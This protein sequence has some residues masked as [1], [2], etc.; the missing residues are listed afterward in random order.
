MGPPSFS[1]PPPEP[2]ATAFEPNMSIGPADQWLC[3]V[4]AAA[5]TAAA[6]LLAAADLYDAGD[7]SGAIETARTAADGV[8]VAMEN[9]QPPIGALMSDPL[10]GAWAQV[11]IAEM[12][13]ASGLGVDVIPLPS[14]LFSSGM[15]R[16]DPHPALA[17]LKQQLAAAR[18]LGRS[19]DPGGQRC[20]SPWR[21]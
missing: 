3:G 18:A 2:S 13:V 10:I 20:G 8:R 19:T 4:V 5:E 17:T 9:G 21:S 12:D 16:P 14:G 6:P 11:A 15:P 1:M 7:S